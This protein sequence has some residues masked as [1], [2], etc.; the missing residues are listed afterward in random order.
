MACRV[1]KFSPLCLFACFYLQTCETCVYVCGHYVGLRWRCV[2]VCARV[3]EC[4]CYWP[5]HRVN[6]QG[7]PHHPTPRLSLS[8]WLHASVLPLF[9]CPSCT[10]CLSQRCTPA[11]L[12]LSHTPGALSSVGGYTPNFD[13]HM[14]E[15]NVT[16]QT[17]AQFTILS[18]KTEAT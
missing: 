3:C 18:D 14:T 5:G 17:G 8:P 2:C 4:V 6:L 10:A 16:L 15:W 13:F 9:L 7:K 1:D 11:C 12:K